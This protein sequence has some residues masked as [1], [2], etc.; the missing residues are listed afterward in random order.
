M[1]F[2]VGLVLISAVSVRLVFGTDDHQSA[3]APELAAPH[4]AQVDPSV[5]QELA[6][7]RREVNE[8]RRSANVNPP[9]QMPV[10]A[11]SVADPSIALRPELTGPEKRAFLEQSFAAEPEDPVWA[12]ST[13]RAIYDVMARE[14]LRGSEIV[15]AQCR[16]RVCRVEVRHESEAA[17]HGFL[18]FFTA[19]PPLTGAG[20]AE[21][22]RD[23]SD[24]TRVSTV[25]F[26][27]REGQSLPE[28]P[29]PF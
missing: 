14:E 8:L 19:D 7:L 16:S 1:L 22:V 26:F 17:Q 29:L 27:A 4:V 3:T 18:P 13:E 9:P 25:I 12:S 11:E 6:A 10:V 20:T 23:P 24:P 21:L 5:A 2:V 28:P 15:S